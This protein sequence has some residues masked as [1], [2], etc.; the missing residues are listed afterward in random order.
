MSVQQKV[1]GLPVIVHLIA[2]M[3]N[4]VDGAQKSWKQEAK[5]Y[6]SC[7]RLPP[8]EDPARD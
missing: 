8:V 7:A 6:E 1:Q 4:I 5:K 2:V 3:N